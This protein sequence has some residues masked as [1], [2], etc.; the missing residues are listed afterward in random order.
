MLSLLANWGSCHFIVESVS[1]T[2]L[3]VHRRWRY[4]WS[5][6][7]VGILLASLT[8]W[9]CVAQCI[10][11]LEHAFDVL[12]FPSLSASLVVC[13]RRGEHALAWDRMVGPV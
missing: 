1:T 9:A 4:V 12:P 3:P 5:V 2:I 11:L 8:S 13:T 7:Q 6:L 10:L